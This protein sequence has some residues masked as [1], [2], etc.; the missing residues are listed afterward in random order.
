MYIKDTW[1]CDDEDRRLV[2]RG[3]NLGGSSKIP[4]SLYRETDT[5]AD[6][7]GNSTGG[8][9]GNDG[10]LGNGGNG[11][12][13][14]NGGCRVSFS[15]RPFPLEEADERFAELAG[16]GFTFN[17]LV[18][19]WEALEHDGPG[20]YDEAYLAYLRKL[21]LC[22]EKRGVSVFIDPHQDVWGRAA[23]GDGAPS[24]TL[25]KLGID[26]GRL[27]D[28][29]AILPR[30]VTGIAAPEHRPVM[31]WPAGYNRYAAATMFTLFFAGGVFAPKSS[32]DGEGVQDW[33]Q[34][35]YIEA[36]A[37]ARRRLKNCK[38][39]AGWGI[40]NEPHPGFIGCT[41]LSRLE[42][43]MVATGP[44]PSPFAAMAAASGHTVEIP[45]YSTGIFGV[46][47]KGTAVLNPRKTG[48]FTG[49]FSCPWKTAGVWSDQEGS[50]RLLRPDYFARSKGRF[51]PD[52]LE[53]FI[54]RFT[55][56]IG[57]ADEKTFFFIEGV[58]AG[59]GA[60]DSL[61][62]ALKDSDAAF[63]AGQPNVNSAETR[64]P[65]SAESLRPSPRMV[66]AFHW[67]DGPTLFIKQFRPW[68]NYDTRS[69]KIVLGKKAVKRLYR[70][71]IALYLSNDMPN[72]VG[73]F[74][75]PFDLFRGKAFK[76]GDYRIHEEALSM[77]YD[78]ID[79]YLLSSSV[80]CYS[81]DNVFSRG[82]SWNNEDFSIVT[83]GSGGLSPLPRAAA[84]WLRPY[85][86]ATAGTP[87][88]FSWNRNTKSLCF[89]FRTDPSI[90]APTELFIPDGVWDKKP[91]VEARP[92]S[93]SQTGPHTEYRPG[94]R[95]LLVYHN[96]FDGD[97][98]LR[99]EPA[100]QEFVALRA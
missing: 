98:E 53:P 62:G 93:P 50:P 63:R 10:C 6:W 33:L 52:F 75:L 37:H 82:D 97:V 40:M 22:A 72:M 81:A 88:F 73:E 90:T 49:G 58:P 35:R 61:R 77:Y 96:G 36:F 95:R 78:A 1:I 45:V 71:Q 92:A 7:T 27:E 64:M 11:G 60:G 25:E 30:G 39:I 29:G 18:V 34:N 57:E 48:I 66:H 67:Y 55:R 43:N 79:E 70:E 59:I 3:C 32:V 24:W 85:P 83:T 23:G 89:R 100:G 16:W 86:A 19:C 65:L 17:R 13:L 5:V 69:G 42:N 41:D 68:F 94:E 2:L 4:A 31:T 38:A 44:M 76:T 91:L 99:A 9:L 54:K 84:G 20:I 80:W 26:I 74:G 56:R 28:S 8:S 14:G 46:K 21:L 51:V 87:L 12:C 15:G 47:R